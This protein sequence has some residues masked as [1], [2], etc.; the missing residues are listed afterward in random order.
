[1]NFDSVHNY[2]EKMVFERVRQYIGRK[3]VDQD[4]MEDIACV[5]LNHLP[6]RYIRHEVDMIFYLS[7]IE[8]EEMEEKIMQAIEDAVEIIR[9]KQRG[10]KES[11]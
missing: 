3:T 2:Y 6:P 9:Q 4:Y 5:A 11:A 1:M 7:P 10:N 8:R